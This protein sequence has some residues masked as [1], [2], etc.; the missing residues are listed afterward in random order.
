MKTR[1]AWRFVLP[2]LLV[3]AAPSSAQATWTAPVTLS[4]AGENAAVSQVGVDQL[5]NAVFVWQRYDGSASCNPSYGCL[6]IQTRARSAAGSLSAVQTLSGAGKDAALPQVAV[7]SNGN[8]Y[9]VWEK[10]DATTDC[11]GSGCLRIQLRVRSAAGA[12]S[13]VQTLSGAGKSAV[14]PQI[15]IDQNDDAVVV[16]ARDDGSSSSCCTRIQTRTRSADGTLSTLQ[17]LSSSGN[18]DSPQVGVDAGADAVFIWR[19]GTLI[20]DR[21]RSAGGTLSAVQNLSSGQPTLSPEVGVDQSGNALFIWVR[22]DGSTDCNFGGRSGPCYRIQ[23]A[24]RSAAGTLSAVQTL[25][26]PGQDALFPEVAVD[27]S[28][29]AA[30]TWSR[31]DGTTGCTFSIGCLR[32][33]TVVRS[34]AGVLSTVQTLSPSGQGAFNPQV[35]M[36]QSDKA[37]FVWQAG[38]GNPSSR[39]KSRTRAANGT[40]SAVQIISGAATN[41][42]EPQVAVNPSGNAI[43]SWSSVDGTTDCSGHGCERINAAA[44][45]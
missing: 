42:T 8:A 30:F 3:F 39:I 27:Q 43:A 2:L 23:A 10:Q 25:S 34:S 21:A 36:D 28:G 12:L 11:G 18:A 19:R 44:G 37:V 6:R 32:A 38:G 24:A 29:N 31:Y 17:T 14:S 22:R 41:E 33:Q 45:P 26:D 16:W 40:L 20:E 5:G 13:A 4:D 15:A 7:D 9:F 1:L 35:G